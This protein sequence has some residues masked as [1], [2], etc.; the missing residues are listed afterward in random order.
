MNMA[1]PYKYTPRNLRR[2]KTTLS[3]RSESSENLREPVSVYCRIRPLEEIETS[4]LSIVSP[5]ILSLNTPNENKFLTQKELHCQFKHIFTSYSGQKE[6]FDYVGMPL[7]KDLINGKNSLLFT[8]G[9]TGSGK[10]FTV[11]GE[12]ENPG[13][14]G[15]SITTLFNTIG[16]LQANKFVI[17]PDKMNGFEIQSENDALQDRLIEVRTG[18]SK[19]LR[20]KASGEKQVYSND[21]TRIADVD[22]NNFYAV[23]ISY[24]EIYNNF[25]FDLLEEGKALQSKILR[26]DKYKSIYVNG[27]VEVEVKSAEEA[28]NLLS[29]GQKQK[30]MGHTILNSESSRSHSV[31]S[32]R[33]V[34]IE[35]VPH[36]NDGQ[37]IGSDNLLR[38][39]QLSLVDLAGSERNN[40]TQTTGVRLKEASNIN[41]SLMCLRNC[42]EALRENQKGGN[43]M[44][45]YRDSRLTYLFKSFFEGYGKVQMIVCINPSIQNYEENLH[46]LKFAEMTQEVKIKAKE[47]RLLY[48]PQKTIQK[49]SRTPITIKKSTSAIATL[50]HLPSFKFNIDNF[51]E[52]GN[53]LEQVGKGI[54]SHSNKSN[55]RFID[56]SN[57]CDSFRKNLTKVYE[58]NILNQAEVKNFKTL[59]KRKQDE[60][61]NLN[62]K[63]NDLETVNDS[64]AS[65]NEELQDVIRL[66]NQRIDE[67]DLKINQ[68]ILEKRKE[69]QKLE[70]ATEKMAQELDYK[71]KKQ[72][73]HLNEKETKEANM[74]KAKLAKVKE[75]IESNTCPVVNSSQYPVSNIENEPPKTSTPPQGFDPKKII[76][77]P[78]PGI[79]HRRSRSA[80]EMWLEHNA[81]KPVPLD[82]VLQPS[83]KKRKSLTKLSKASD[84]TN[85]KQSKYCLLTQNL[86]DDGE[87]E[88]KVYKGDILPTCG[89]GAQVVFNDLELLKQR[90][91]TDSN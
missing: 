83:I 25:V 81:I 46:V 29:L 1:T 84:I 24:I 33:L 75:I 14:I 72:R 51:Q 60:V 23:F 4:C 37:P 40:R 21:G 71:L 17:K 80:G 79:R 47:N 13:I 64:L 54:K 2:E 78:R 42:L 89:G 15:R 87:P 90:S 49:N 88:T 31:F 76:G 82:T 85:P 68:Q 73:Q 27:I 32:I 11:T 19:G 55:N 86:G 18:K 91:P 12:P 62:C 69:K 6:V 36:N 7:V 41:N 9:V 77:T 45:N 43:K 20:D 48:T 34:Q 67:K 66:L 58:Q 5:T 57:M 65:K 26:E 16:E 30:R 3:S 22:E 35:K 10:T 52:M 74:V 61:S 53:V 59:V 28:F 8:Y 38:V 70:I 44:V 39:S 50:F 63:V 56:L